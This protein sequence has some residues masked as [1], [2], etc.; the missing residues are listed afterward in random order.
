VVPGSVAVDRVV[1]DFIDP[2]SR[3]HDT[4]TV[5]GKLAV[6]G[7]LVLGTTATAGASTERGLAWIENEGALLPDGTPV[8]PH[9]QPRWAFSGG[10]LAIAGPDHSNRAAQFFFAPYFTPMSASLGLYYALGDGRVKLVQT[11]S[12]SPFGDAPAGLNVPA[13]DV[14]GRVDVGT[15]GVRQAQ[16]GFVGT[17]TAAFASTYAGTTGA[18]ADGQLVQAS[19]WDSISMYVTD[20]TIPQNVGNAVTGSTYWVAKGDVV[21]RKVGN[22]LVP[23]VTRALVTAGNHAIT[24]ALQPVSVLNTQHVFNWARTGESGSA[25]LR[26]RFWSGVG[27]PVEAYALGSGSAPFWETASALGEWHALVGN[28]TPLVAEGA[29]TY[30]VVSGS[31]PPG[32]SLSDAG[33]LTGAYV[34]NMPSATHTFV[35]RASTFDYT[36]FTDREFQVVVAS[37]PVWTSASLIPGATPGVQV[38][39]DLIASAS[40]VYT[41]VSGNLPVGIQLTIVSGKARLSGT[42]AAGDYVFTLRAS[43]AAY[44]LTSDKLF[45]WKIA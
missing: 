39:V 25:G 8:V 18:I 11:F 3:Q 41:K 29:T 32:M 20:T 22:M 40:T 15:A 6:E 28:V 42:P 23:T 31:L 4:V 9:E 33:S 35:I 38:S 27:L 17:G 13:I 30:T 7:P 19:T 5:T 10:G 37:V 1:T 26:V 24:P 2:K 44:S 45:T 21:V 36:S 14:T 43:N 16:G 34:E 12:A